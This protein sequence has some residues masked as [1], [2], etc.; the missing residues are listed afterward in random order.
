MRSRRTARS[1]EECLRADPAMAR[2]D[3]H[4]SR[5][6][7]LQAV[8]ALALPPNLARAS[9]VA[10]LKSGTLL[11]HADNGAVAAKLRQMAPR[12]VDVVRFEAAEVTGI[13]I[14]VQ[15]R[16]ADTGKARGETYDRIGNKAK[17]GLTSLEKTLPEGSRLRTALEWLVRR[18]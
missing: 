15:G 1:L 17:Q 18:G 14:R 12:L 2:L 11:I 5:L 9:R 13:D 16:V 3:G 10:N 7:R 4:A 6:L 8:V